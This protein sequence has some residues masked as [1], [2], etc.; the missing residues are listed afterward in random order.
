MPRK[1]DKRLGRPSKSGASETNEEPPSAPPINEFGSEFAIAKKTEQPAIILHAL[2]VLDRLAALHSEWLKHFHLRLLSGKEGEPPENTGERDTVEDIWSAARTDPY[3][4]GNPLF[5]RIISDH[6]SLLDQAEAIAHTSRTSGE[7][8]FEQYTRLMDAVLEMSGN[9]RQ[10]QNDAWNL[11]ANVDPLTGLGNRQAMWKRIRIEAERHSRGDQPCCVAMVDL[12]A[13]KP[14]ND[15][16]GHVAG[17]Q[18]LER[19]AVML[20]AGTRPYDAV[21]RFGGDEFVLCLPNADVDGAW[22]I[23]ERL[24][25]SIA[26]TAIT[27]DKHGE[28]SLTVS[29]G[30]ASLAGDHGAECAVEYADQALYAAKRSG[31]NRVYIWNG[32]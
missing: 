19:V 16:Y 10:V 17:D 26:A 5:V 23:L 14:I 21:F 18:V 7:L 11:V 1:P 3:L 27:L 22:A 2:H 4:H 32:K 24:R 9:L 25:H 31:R 15:H 8:P 13:F 12:D 20:A 28:I 6:Q 29:V 30:I